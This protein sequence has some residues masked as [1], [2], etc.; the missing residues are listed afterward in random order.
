MA[1]IN[2][3]MCFSLKSGTFASA[4]WVAISGFFALLFVILDQA[5]SDSSTFEISGS[6]VTDWRVLI[7]KQWL[8]CNIVMI[9]AHI[10]L[11]GLSIAVCV[12]HKNWVIYTQIPLL[13]AW[14]WMMAIYILCE[15]IIALYEFTW[16]GKNLFRI[17]SMPW[18]TFIFFFWLIRTIFNML[19]L[20]CVLSRVQDIEYDLEHG[21]KKDITTSFGVDTSYPYA[22][23]YGYDGYDYSD[24]PGYGYAEGYD[25]QGYPAD[26]QGY[27][28]DAY[29]YPV[30]GYDYDRTYEGQGYYD[31][32]GQG[33]GSSSYGRGYDSYGYRIENTQAD[34][35]V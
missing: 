32:K 10:V 12:A 14:Y 33:E 4:L 27:P 13:K 18:L 20:V 25:G 26:G 1:L 6:F 17:L 34:S 2:K 30:E 7:W 3:C 35:A 16:Y 19:A 23:G 15:F 31:G 22:A 11:V 5:A 24:Y 9:F 28:T 29:G 8:A 21:D